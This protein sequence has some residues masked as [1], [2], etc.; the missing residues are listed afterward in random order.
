V[1][2]AGQLL[3]AW[4]LAAL[5]FASTF[6]LPYALY[7]NKDSIDAVCSGVAGAAHARWA[8]LGISRKQ[9]AA[10][11]FVLICTIWM[12]ISWSNRLIGL[13]MGALAIRCNLKP[14][15]VAAIREHAAP[16]TISV[17]KRAARMSI[18]ASDFAQRTLG[19]KMHFR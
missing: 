9:K 18:A 10:G 13:L 16:L 2:I 17:K 3:S 5:G 12:R 7:T 14:A 15:E 1:A 8:A 6:T 19:N 11:L 4:T